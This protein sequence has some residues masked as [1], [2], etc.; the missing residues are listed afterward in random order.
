MTPLVLKN[1]ANEVGLEQNHKLRIA[2]GMSCIERVQHLLTQQQIIDCFNIG[3]RFL[4]GNAIE[5]A[6]QQAAKTATVLA[7]QHAGSNSFD[8]AG[9]AAV[10]T[11]YGVAAALHGQALTAAE[12]T[13]YAKVYSY[14]SYA[15]TDIANYTE[16]H[17]WQLLKLRELIATEDYVR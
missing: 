11:S 12:Y 9:S 14:S 13:A 8:G 3:M 1:L 15:V 7:A 4:N 6:L 10:S 17:V 2:F 16:E 5:A